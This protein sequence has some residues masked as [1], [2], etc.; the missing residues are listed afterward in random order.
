L[1]PPV[2]RLAETARMPVT[3]RAAVRPARLAVAVARPVVERRRVVVRPVV[4]VARFAFRTARLTVPPTVRP[5]VLLFRVEVFRRGAVVPRARSTFLVAFLATRRIV[6]T[7]S[8][9]MCSPRKCR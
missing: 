6:P 8:V 5:R 7:M 9:V 4:P 1:A 2:A 3:F